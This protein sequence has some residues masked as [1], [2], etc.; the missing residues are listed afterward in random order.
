MSNDTA[1]TAVVKHYRRAHAR[2]RDKELVTELV[3]EGSDTHEFLTRMEKL[4]LSRPCTRTVD[5]RGKTPYK[6]SNYKYKNQTF[7]MDDVSYNIFQDGL[8]AHDGV[9]TVGT[10]ERIVNGAHTF[11]AVQQAQ[12]NQQASAAT[13]KPSQHA[14]NTEPNSPRVDASAP[15]PLERYRSKAAP[16][17]VLP[18]G[19]YYRRGEP[20]VEWISEVSLNSEGQLLLG[21][22]RDVSAH[23]LRVHCKVAPPLKPGD[24]LEVNFTAVTSETGDTLSNVPYSIVAIEAHDTATLLRLRQHEDAPAPATNALAKLVDDTLSSTRSRDQ[25]DVADDV[26]TAASLLVEK[27]YTR[28]TP[29]VPFVIGRDSDKPARVIAVFSND[30]NESLLAPFRGRD[31]RYALEFLTAA[32]LCDEFER[33]MANDYREESVLAMWSDAAGQPVVLA[34]SVCAS[35]EQWHNVLLGHARHDGFRVFKLTLHQVSTPQLTKLQRQVENLSTKAPEDAQ[36]L[37]Q[38]LDALC[39][40]GAIVDVTAEIALE[41]VEPSPMGTP[42]PNIRGTQNP[43]VL[44]FGTVEHRREER[45]RVTMDV[46]IKAGGHQYHGKT[47]DF[48]IRGASIRVVGDPEGVQRG[49]TVKLTFPNLQKRALLRT[50]LKDIPYEIVEMTVDEDS[51]V[52][53]LKR[54]P[55]KRQESHTAFFKE[56]IDTNRDKL[57]LDVTEATLVAQSR[58][59][60]SVIAESTGTIPLLLSRDP[61]SGERTVRVAL[62]AQPGPL[63][64]FFE[65]A[66]G[67]YDFSALALPTRLADLMKETARGSSTS[68]VLYLF[69]RQL[70]G[71]HE[72][73]ILAAAS[74]QLRDPKERS[75]FAQAAEG[76]DFRVVKLMLAPAQELAEHEINAVLDPLSSAA[77]RDTRELRR[78]LAGIVAVGDIIDVT[79]HVTLG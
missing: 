32:E 65:V 79:A 63:A 23:G 46:S 52:L 33:S 54:L 58:L 14:A 49:E 18:L 1:I 66:P 6:C 74:E 10:Y 15:D 28:A 16:P 9:F 55:D 78:K 45:Y 57:P 4:R 36:R 72:F 7:W 12:Q 70:A 71:S 17:E 73:E 61:S 76:H 42:P 20:R 21:T 2:A 44:V 26:I 37:V 75:H 64:E 22:T 24:K 60:E 51:I 27:Y 11:K 30:N 59:Y 8:N 5:M 19:Y 29:V 67:R 69:K 39:A 13:L 43:R 53:H 25:R 77:P 62:P 68:A 47:E 50:N 41:D 40:V 56:L 35:E 3:K 48:S 31:A 34:K 38:N